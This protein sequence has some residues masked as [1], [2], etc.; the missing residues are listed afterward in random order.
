MDK[1]AKVSAHTGIKDIV[2]GGGVSANSGLRNAIVDYGK[3]RGWNTFLPELRFTTDNAAMI[4][5]TAYFKYRAGLFSSHQ[6]SPLPRY[7]IGEVIGG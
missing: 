1:L 5:V 6:V 4:A 3:S 2:I 7:P